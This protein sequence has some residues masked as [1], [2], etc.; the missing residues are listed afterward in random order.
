VIII[1]ENKEI[2]INLKEDEIPLKEEYIGWLNEFK[3]N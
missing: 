1:H 2:F 3:K